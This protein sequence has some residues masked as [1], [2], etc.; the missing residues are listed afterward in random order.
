MK[1]NELMDFIMDN[2]KIF[3]YPEELLKLDME[4]SKTELFAILL[5]DRYGEIMMSQ[6]ADYV[7]IPMSTATGIA[8]RLVRNGYLSRERSETD[9][10]IVVVKLADKGKN[11]AERFKALVTDKAARLFEELTAEELQVLKNVYNKAV[12]II[13]S[14]SA[15]AEAPREDGMK[16]IEIE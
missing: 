6:I 11:M 7:N 10:R 9:R 4:L 3:L 12:K 15:T 1:Y 13:G 5:V 14:D 8:D 2:F 16:K